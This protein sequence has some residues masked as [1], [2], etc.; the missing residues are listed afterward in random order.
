[1]YI[2]NKIRMEVQLQIGLRRDERCV[3]YF[4]SSIIMNI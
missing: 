2:N 4:S 1:M 3:L